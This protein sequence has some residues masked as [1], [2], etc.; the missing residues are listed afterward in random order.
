MNQQLQNTKQEGVL[1]NIWDGWFRRE[2][3]EKLSK[4]ERFTAR[5]GRNGPK[6]GDLL[7]GWRKT[8]GL[9]N[10]SMRWFEPQ[11][12]IIYCTANKKSVF[13][14]VVSKRLWP[15]W[16]F[17]RNNALLYFFEYNCVKTAFN[18]KSMV[19]WIPLKFLAL[20]REIRTAC[21]VNT[22]LIGRQLPKFLSEKYFWMYQLL[23]K[24]IL[25]IK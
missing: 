14:F 3:P 2:P 4:T 19:F 16:N 11:L 8:A 6:W 25:W 20:Y 24:N 21:L 1:R 15:R 5:R 9:W 18:I 10:S 12:K 17:P 23:R 7:V 22:F 13:S